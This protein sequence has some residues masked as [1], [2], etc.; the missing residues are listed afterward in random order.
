M[1]VQSKIKKVSAV[2]VVGMCVAVVGV[3]PVTTAL[4]EGPMSRSHCPG[5][6]PECDGFDGNR[7][8]YEIGKNPEM[9]V[10]LAVAASARH[11]D[12]VLR[13]SSIAA[14]LLPERAAEVVGALA[15]RFPCQV[16]GVARSAALSAPLYGDEIAR[17]AVMVVPEKKETIERAVGAATMTLEDDLD[18]MPREWAD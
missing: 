13:I 2:F 16:R 7:L 15:S 9:V 18:M 11:P 1:L 4:A 14:R 6:C 5:T 12:K 17:A 10:G 3:L 8:S